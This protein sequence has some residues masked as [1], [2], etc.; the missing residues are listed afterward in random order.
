MAG[1]GQHVVPIGGRW[2]VMTTGASR[3]SKTYKTLEQALSDARE[4]AKSTG[5][6]LYIHGRD[7]RITARSDFNTPGLPSKG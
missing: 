1:R 3:A 2:R 4:R 6:K 5:A 7:G